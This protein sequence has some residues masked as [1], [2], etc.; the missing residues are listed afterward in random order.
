MQSSKCLLMA[1]CGFV[2][3]PSGRQVGIPRSYS[4]SF[5]I[6]IFCFKKAS[7]SVCCPCRHICYIPL[8]RSDLLQYAMQLFQLKHL[9]VLYLTKVPKI[10][11]L[12]QRMHRNIKVWFMSNPTFAPIRMHATRDFQDW[13]SHLWDSKYSARNLKLL[14]LACLLKKATRRRRRTFNL[15]FI[16]VSWYKIMLTKIYCNKP[17]FAVY[18]H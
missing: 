8:P 13:S 1:L 4:S 15:S 11:S 10:T 6:W 7:L 17:I 14:A 2:F 18:C 3:T 12:M 9:L 16:W 5:L